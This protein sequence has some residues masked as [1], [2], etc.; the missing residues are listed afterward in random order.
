MIGANGY[1]LSGTT[2]SGGGEPMDCRFSLN[3][4]QLTYVTYSPSAILLLQESHDATGWMTIMTVT[5]TTTTAT[6]QISSFYP[7]V[8]GVFS[9]GWSTTAS[10]VMHYAPG[11]QRIH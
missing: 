10:A 11:I 4:A 9:T 5:G 7:Y 2:A 6:A 1:L 8:R 3:Y